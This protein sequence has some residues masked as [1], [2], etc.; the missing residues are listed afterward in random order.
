MTVQ[1]LTFS[2]GSEASAGPRIGG[3]AL[4]GGVA[5]WPVAPDGTQLTLVASVPGSFVNTH[6]RAGIVPGKHVS[7]FTYYGPANYFLDH[8]T[9]HGDPSELAIISAGYTQVLVHERGGAVAGGELLTAQDI[10]VYVDDSLDEVTFTGSKVGGNP[11]FLQSESIQLPGVFCLQLASHDFLEPHEDVLGL[12][13]AVGYM[14]LN[15]DSG[16]FFTQVT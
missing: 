8:V 10:D 9:F 14:Y 13:D 5:R 12:A 11:A 3:Q 6:A 1:T 4:I 2:L 15:R 16:T 7:V